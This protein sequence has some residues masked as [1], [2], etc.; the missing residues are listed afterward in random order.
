MLSLTPTDLPELPADALLLLAWDERDGQDFITPAEAQ[1]ALSHTPGA[2]LFAYEQRD[3]TRAAA[4]LG[5]ALTP[6]LLRR[7]YPYTTPERP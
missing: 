1:R 7:A 2:Y 5:V 6:D 4:H 3:L